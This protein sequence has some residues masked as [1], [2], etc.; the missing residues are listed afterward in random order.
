MKSAGYTVIELV[1]TSLLMGLLFCG[2]LQLLG[3]LATV[4]RALVKDNPIVNGEDSEFLAAWLH[5]QLAGALR[6]EVINQGKGLRY[7]KRD[8]LLEVLTFKEASGKSQLEYQID[9]QAPWQ[10]QQGIDTKNPHFSLV[11]SNLLKIYLVSPT[12]P[13]SI[14]LRN[15]R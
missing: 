7:Q 5:L 6:V 14:W 10:V 2:G 4:Q 3:N 15:I 1:V 11:R 12:R 8:G 9:D 13:L